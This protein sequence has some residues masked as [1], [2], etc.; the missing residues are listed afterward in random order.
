MAIFFAVSNNAAACGESM[1]SEYRCVVIDAPVAAGCE[2]LLAAGVRDGGV[3]AVF[4]LPPAHARMSCGGRHLHTSS[5]SS[6]RKA[7][8]FGSRPRK[9]R[10]STSPS[11]LPP[12]SR[13]VRR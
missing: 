12:R 13:I 10:T 2:P 8:L 7:S 5:P 4:S 6:R 11:T 3:V 9:S 1:G